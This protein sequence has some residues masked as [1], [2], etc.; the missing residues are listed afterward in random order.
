MLILDDLIPSFPVGEKFCETH[1]VGKLC[2]WVTACAKEYQYAC[3]C[4][5]L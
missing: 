4:H 3:M 5:P 1:F 2:M